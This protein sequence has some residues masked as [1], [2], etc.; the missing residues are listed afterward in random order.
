MH[1]LQKIQDLIQ[2]GAL[3]VVNHSG[4]K[5]SQAMYLVLR[6]LV[7]REQLTIVHA[8]LGEVEW[9]GA[10]DHIKATICGESIHVC[11][12]PKT[13]L[14]MVEHNQRRHAAASEPEKP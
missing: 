1:T 2:R 7:P 6:D 12:A 13:L 9:A 11:K 14:D 3:F 10:V 8:D 5:D 4:G